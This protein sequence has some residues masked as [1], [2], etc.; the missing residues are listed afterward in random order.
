[1][2]KTRHFEHAPK[3]IFFPF[4]TRGN[5]PDGEGILLVMSL[6]FLG[7]FGGTKMNGLFIALGFHGIF[8]FSA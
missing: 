1:V 4:W 5:D 6:P 2:F 3:L 7:N 8:A